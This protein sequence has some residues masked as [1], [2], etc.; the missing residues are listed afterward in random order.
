[1]KDPD[2]VTL[3]PLRV[4][5]K[6]SV[7]ISADNWDA[8]ILRVQQRRN[9]IHSYKHRDIGTLDELERD[10]RKYWDFVQDLDDRVPY[11]QKEYR[12]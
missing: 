11:P 6:R 10:I 7:W 2:A 5:F 3:E 9:A 1:M 12:P 4:F 8:W